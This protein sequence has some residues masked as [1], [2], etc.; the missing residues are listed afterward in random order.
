MSTQSAKTFVT[1]VTVLAFCAC[2]DAA[3]EFDYPRDELLRLNH[4]QAK[5]THN[6][7]HL[8]PD[9][10]ELADWN[11]T[12]TPLGD[13]LGV[14][15]IRQFELDININVF[16]DRF[17]VY[18]IV[19]IDEGTTCFLL[20]DCLRDMKRWSDRNPAHHPIVAMVEIKDGYDDSYAEHFFDLF[21]SEL[22]SIWPE[23]RLVTP[24]LVRG[25]Y[26]T[27]REALA[28]RGWPTLGELR[29]RALFFFLDRGEYRDFYTHGETSLDG[30]L[31]FVTASMDKPYGAITS[32]DNPI[33]EAAEI[34]AAAEAG[35]LVRTRVDTLT[36]QGPEVDQTRL[37][38]ALASGAHFLSTDVEDLALP[39]G[40]PSR[41]NPITA[42]AECAPADLEDP[43][44]ME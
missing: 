9:P 12:H 22:L 28:D 4:L 14:H 18:H 40:S 27:L 31:A 11:Y 17:E 15:G 5:G 25:A 13:Q 35:M 1:A 34:D 3:I 23:D 44:F 33:A 32:L 16:D 6:S 29:G 42:P 21:E 39:D 20:T 43:Q 7:Y 2:G 36:D 38:A 26:A 30:R 41:C 24:D 10:F 8:A 19:R 37:E